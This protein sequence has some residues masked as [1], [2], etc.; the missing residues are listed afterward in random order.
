MVGE[1]CAPDILHAAELLVRTL[2]SGGKVL[3]F[4]NGGS[5]ADA[6]HIGA[7]LTG[8]FVRERQPFPAISL[9]TDPSA[10]TAIAN[11]Y[12]YEHVFERQVLAHGRPGDLAV[13]I[14]TSGTSKNVVLAAQA[15]RERGMSVVGLVGAR[16]DV[17]REVADVT[18]SVPST[19]AA[20]IQECHITIGHVLCEI[21]DEI[22]SDSETVVTTIGPSPVATLD[23]L[24]EMREVWRRHKVRVVWTN[25]CFDVI[26]AGHVASL[27]AARQ[28][29]DL[30]VV[31]LNSDVS[32]RALKGPSRPIFPQ[33]QRAAV[34]AAFD[35]VDH[36]LVFDDADP[37][38]IIG[39]LQPDVCCKGA[40]YAPPSGK[41]VPEAAVVESYGGKM[42]YLPLVEGLSTSST[43]KK[44]STG[45]PS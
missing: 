11:D 21:A 6:Q 35:T 33:E 29:G 25:G 45:S 19:S 3:L 2:R 12:G 36:V 26:H 10:V 1:V 4:G 37:A 17:M 42:A 16:S 7:E 38:A 22:L 41:P 39:R 15:A 5:A 40:D 24:L 32:V 8:R 14:S 30:L 31:G 27:A 13:A 20:R 18:V 9:S 34:L 23:Q 43:I 44:L 28:H